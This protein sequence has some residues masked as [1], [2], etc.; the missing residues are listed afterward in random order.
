MTVI[1]PLHVHR[2]YE[3]LVLVGPRRGEVV[4]EAHVGR[5]RGAVEQ[6][7]SARV[8]VRD[9]VQRLILVRPDDDRPRLD[10]RVGVLEVHDVEFLHR[11][12]GRESGDGSRRNSRRLPVR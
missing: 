9:G 7:L 5:D 1:V 12:A 6:A 2:V 10:R 11:C 8:Y 3:A 4:A